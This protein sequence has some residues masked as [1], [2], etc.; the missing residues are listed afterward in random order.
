MRIAIIANVP[1]WTLPGLENLHHNRH[2][3]TWLE[4]LIPAFERFS[5]EIDLH[6]ITMCKETSHA[7]EHKAFGQT[8][9]IMPRGRLSV[10]MATGYIGEILRIRQILTR[11]QPNLV[12][13]WGSEDVCGLAGAFSGIPNRIFTLQ[14]CFTEYVRLLGGSALFRLQA[15]YERP[16]VRR[17]GIGTAESPTAAELLLE[18]NP[19][20]RVDLVDY[21]V[22]RDFFDSRWVPAEDPELV[23]VGGICER[24][25]ILDLI[26]VAKHQHLSHIKFSILG[27]G[28]L[29]SALEALSTPNVEWLGK[30]S[31]QEVIQHLSK[32]WAL[33]IPTYADTGPTVIKEARVVGLP[34]IT[35]TSAGASS[36][37]T[38]SGCGVVITS[39][40]QDALAEG[41]LKVCATRDECMRIGQAGWADHRIVLQP[42]TTAEKFVSL[43]R[44]LSNC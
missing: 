39:G 31:R 16:S 10:S 36:Y 18:M 26:Q 27:E 11:L 28:P 23:F 32:A 43:Y 14:G 34:V 12:H 8:F 30:C 5:S 37:V 33:V 15:C 38:E 44:E 3:A 41:I 35:T 20:M 4:P 21:G 24:K 25:G 2:Y 13:A 7:I 1:V 40:D 29:R 42:N 19:G 22:S 17:Y 9:H 6:W